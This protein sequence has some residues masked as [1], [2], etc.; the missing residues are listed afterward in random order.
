MGDDRALLGRTATNF[1]VL[2]ESRPASRPDELE[3]LHIF[4]IFVCWDAVVLRK[5]GQSEPSSSQ[6]LRKLLAPEA[7]IE[8]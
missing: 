6:S 5:S 2:H 3:P 8:E 1:R 7:P 4:N